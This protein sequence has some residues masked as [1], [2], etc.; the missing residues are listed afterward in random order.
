MREKKEIPTGKPGVSPDCKF[1]YRVWMSV[2]LSEPEICMHACV[3][4]V[5]SAAFNSLKPC[6]P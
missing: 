6:G 3:H 1:W 4:A 5:A 2:F